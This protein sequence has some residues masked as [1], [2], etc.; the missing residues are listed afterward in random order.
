MQPNPRRILIGAIGAIAA[1]GALAGGAAASAATPRSSSA[2]RGDVLTIGTSISNGSLDPAKA[3]PGTDPIFLNP[4][5]APLIRYGTNGQ[6]E[7]VLASSW[8]YV[9]SGYK[10]FQIT[11]RPD[12]EFS[13][14]TGV[15][16]AAVAASIEHYYK[17][18]ATAGQ[19]MANCHGVTALSKLV[20]QIKCT[21]PDPDLPATLTDEELGG[22]IVA[23]SA[24]AHPSSIATKPV[25]A[26]EY[27]LDAAATVAGSTYTY[28]A[29]PR[30][31]DQAAI[32]WK[33]LVVKVFT[34]PS[35][36]LEA[37]ES[38]QIQ[39]YLAADPNTLQAAASASGV[40]LS[41]APLLFEGVELADRSTQGGNPLGKLKVRQA[42]EYAVDRPA[43][44]KALFGK[45]GS[46]TDEVAIPSQ[47]SAWDPSVNNYYPYDPTKAKALLAE[48]GYPNGFTISVEDQESDAELTQ[49]VVGYWKSIGVQTNVTTD[50]TT[51]G[52]INNVLSKKFP[53][54]GY[55]YG[56]LPM[57]LEAVNWFEPVANI[58][59]PFAT[60]EPSILDTLKH[61]ESVPAAQQN[62]VFEQ[63]QAI[64]VKQAWYVGVALVDAGIIH[65]NSV[66]VPKPTGG[67]IFNIDDIAPAS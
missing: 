13:N 53:A 17:V 9:G 8:R 18:G 19:W 58:Y 40:Q 5:Y 10:K 35:T 24:L 1:A 54:I 64:G 7:G 32:H 42:L 51:P 46:P 28:V 3:N 55:G 31:F 29:N 22:D 15:D 47:P 41:T 26:G 16:A 4:I 36:G 38:G 11:L 25:G 43:I 66:E 23:P 63:A 67:Y 33:K 30:Y 21:Q 48:A 45:F 39:W 6:L 44:V 59:N 65:S 60:D 52:W 57:Y 27:T 34:T 12:V 56:G 62:A 50:S 20:V 14:G 37:L 2:K 49:A 61:A